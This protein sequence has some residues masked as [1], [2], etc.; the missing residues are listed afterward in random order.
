MEVPDD[1]GRAQLLENH[2]HADWHSLPPPVQHAAHLRHAWNH[3]RRAPAFLATQPGHSLQ[4]SFEVYAR[5]INSKDDREEI[6]RV[7]AAVGQ[8]NTLNP[9][10]SISTKT[11]I[12][13]LEL[14]IKKALENQGL[15][16][17]WRREGDSNPR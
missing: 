9:N 12:R 15:S 10:P 1:H 7:D 16:G 13:K 2:D 14:E 6:A 4:V 3:E 17:S 5:W 8:K 11:T